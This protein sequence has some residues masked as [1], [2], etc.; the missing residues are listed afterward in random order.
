M[1]TECS[2]LHPYRPKH[3]EWAAAVADSD[4]VFIAD[5]VEIVGQ[6]V[7]IA[8]HHRAVVDL[9]VHRHNII[10]SQYADEP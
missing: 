1:C 6:E 7:A 10:A 2:W 8:N 5:R 3:Y 9:Q 4:G